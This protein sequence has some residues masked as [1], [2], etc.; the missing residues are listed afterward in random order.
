MPRNDD[1]EFEL[2]MGNRQLLSVFFI[3]VILLGVFFTMDTSSDG[4]HRRF[5]QPIAIARAMGRPWS[6]IPRRGPR[7]RGAGRP[8]I[9]EPRQQRRRPTRPPSS[10][11]NRSPAGNPQSRRR[12]RNPHRQLP[13]SPPPARHIFRSPPF[14][15]PK[16]SCLST[17]LQKRDS[18]RST[19]PFRISRRLFAFW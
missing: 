11:L 14:N 15:G 9:R 13:I 18:M 8:M 12:L 4:T 2:I 19:L 10:K 16:L 6:S 5:Q 17:C 1:G 7:Q 3:V